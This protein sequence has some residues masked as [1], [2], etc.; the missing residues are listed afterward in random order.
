M[1]NASLSAEHVARLIA[2]A[3]RGEDWRKVEK[4]A[5]AAETIPATYVIT[6]ERIQKAHQRPEV[7]GSCPMPEL[8]CEEDR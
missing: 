2:A 3:N 6:E 7:Q 4:D 5:I 1:P 8:V